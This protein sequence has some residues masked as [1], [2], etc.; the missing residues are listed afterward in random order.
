MK[1]LEIRSLEDRDIEPM[2]AAFHVL[3]WDKPRSQYERYLFEQQED[4]RAVLVAFSGGAFAGYLTINWGA[5]YPHF[6]DAGIPEIQDFTVLPHFRREGIG[7]H[8]MDEAERKISRRSSIAGIGVGMSTDYGAA[9]R[10][11]ALR[12][13]VPDGRGLISHGRQLSRGD[14]V[15]VDD[16]LAL[17][18]TKVLAGWAP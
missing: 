12:G 13:Y 14:A 17:Y 8:L 18:L 15:V 4:R 6:Q 7:T 1:H 16:G 3:G 9:Q 5:D 2:A 11:Y 10:L